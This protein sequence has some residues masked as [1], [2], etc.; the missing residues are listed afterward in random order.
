MHSDQLLKSIF[1]CVAKGSTTR[2]PS[3][4]GILY[5]SGALVASDTFVIVVVQAEYDPKLEGKIIDRSGEEIQL[6]PLNYKSV[7]PAVETLDKCSCQYDVIDLL[8]ACLNMPQS[9]DVDNERILID[10]DGLLFY[11]PRVLQILRVFEQLGEHPGIYVGT[12]RILLK[13]KSCT[14]VVVKVIPLK[15]VNPESY[16]VQEAFEIGDLL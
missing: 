16:T 13:S 6:K 3:L 5:D 8:T 7:I 9:P 1:A 15:R 2:Y 14:G 11:P 4:K 10:F 12:D